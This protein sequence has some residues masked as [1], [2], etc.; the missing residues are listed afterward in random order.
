MTHRRVTSTE[1]WRRRSGLGRTAIVVAVGLFV[2]ACGGGADEAAQT[3]SGAPTEPGTTDTASSDTAPSDTAPNDTAPTGTAPTDTSDSPSDGESATTLPATTTSE[4]ALPELVISVAGPEELVFDHSETNCDGSARPDLSTRALRTNGEVSLTLANPIN[5]RLVGPDFD[6]LT[7]SCVP[8][9]SS[10]F[11]HDPAAFD[12]H[13]WMGALYTTNG[14]TVHAIVHNEFHG[15]EA[16]LA[17]SRRALLDGEDPGDW[18]YLARSGDGAL[19]PMEPAESGFTAGGLCIVD[20]W[21]A[22]PDLGC[23]AV[24]RWTSDRDGELVIDVDA[25]QTASGGDGVTVDVR[26][27]GAVVWS[28]SVDDAEPTASIRLTQPV[29]LGSSID[30]GVAAGGDSSF[31]ATELD[32]AITPD[33]ERC[34]GE[35]AAC[36]YVTLTAA[37]SEDGGATFTQTG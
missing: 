21:G 30:I 33:G 8:T 3:A 17:N 26:V 15:Y 37:R 19:S 2:A 23:D 4:V 22:H 25:R 32:I 27:D 20:F 35:I 1:L 10:T 28:A 5:H 31:D 29:L 16:E 12:H 11:D 14:T 18:Q 24:S 6:S 9:L 13:E 7:L 34:T 36:S